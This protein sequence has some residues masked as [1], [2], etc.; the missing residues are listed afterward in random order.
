LIALNAVCVARRMSTLPFVV[1]PRLAAG[2]GEMVADLALEAAATGAEGI[3]LDAD[4]TGADG[5]AAHRQALPVSQVAE[6][7][8]RLKRTSA[9]VAG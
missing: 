4:V 9:A 3:L 5:S 2:L 6:L 8:S 1:N 7:I